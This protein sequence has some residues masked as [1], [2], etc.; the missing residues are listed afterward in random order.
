M[1]GHDPEKW[2]PVFGKIMPQ[3]KPLMLRPGSFALTLLLAMLTG[4]GPLSVDM[5]LASLPS[6]GRLL[7]APTSQVQ[8]TISAYLIGFA[9]A[10]IFHGPLSDR[11]GRRPVLLA[12]LG[13]YLVATLACALS[14]SIETL[15]AA[16][17][18]QAR[19][20]IGRDRAGA[21]RG[22]RHVRRHPHRPR[23]RRAWR[24]SWRWRR[25]WRR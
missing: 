10:Q 17:L 1:L 8:L 21:R 23:A 11:H 24:R 12:A 22:A 3:R 7:G 9:I 18:V 5:Y 6:I 4:L 16:R 15:I 13:I 20:R 25:W 19:G 14:F 2:A